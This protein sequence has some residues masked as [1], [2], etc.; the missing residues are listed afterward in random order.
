MLTA[1]RFARVGTSPLA[2]IIMAGRAFATLNT[3]VHSSQVASLTDE[4]IEV[5]DHDN[6]IGSIPKL[7]AH[8]A[9]AIEARRTH[10]A[11]SVFLFSREDRSLLIQKRASTK[12]VFPREWANT[13]CSHPL[14]N[15]EEMS[16]SNGTNIGIKIAASR[17]MQAE[18]GIWNMQPESFVFKGKILYRKL[19]PGG[20]FGE[21]E[22]DYILFNEMSQNDRSLLAPF[23]NEVEQTEWVRPGPSGDRTRELRQYLSKQSA[24]GFPPTPWFD[25]MVRTPECLETWWESAISDDE[26]F[27][28]DRDTLGGT[29]KSFIH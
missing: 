5:D 7:K 21:S 28:V 3:E 19:S 27:K 15:Q 8:L 11:F 14:F 16:D 29:V 17:R 13:C 18:L 25:L 24:L 26:F 6:V 1:Y 12:I 2:R 10:R 9:D 20:V 4:L 22:V 23:P